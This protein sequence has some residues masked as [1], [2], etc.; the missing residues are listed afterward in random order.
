MNVSTDPTA[1]NPIPSLALQLAQPVAITA[2]SNV[3]SMSNTIDAVTTPA[4]VTSSISYSD[5]AIAP[6]SWAAVFGTNLAPKSDLAT[7]APLPT[8]FDGVTVTIL[9][10]TGATSNAPILFLSPQQ[11]NFLVPTDCPI[12][13]AVVT[14]TSSGKITGRG[15]ILIDSLAPALFSANGSGTGTAL[16]TAVLTHA[17]GSQISA[18]LSQPIDMGQAGDVATLVLYA[19]G[20]RHLSSMSEVTVYLGGVRLP[21]QFAG[22]QGTYYGLDQINVN[23]PPQLRG[24]GASGL[25]VSVNGLFS[26]IVAVNVK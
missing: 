26:N 13:A 21:V 20:L 8:S 19:T 5:Q 10:S 1:N 23:V 17:D 7:T 4:Y 3:N 25:S 14:V 12:G 11:I 16:G 2:S 24:T 22:S 9:D 6:D 15:A 18:P